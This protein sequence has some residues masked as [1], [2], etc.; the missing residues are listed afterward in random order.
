MIRHWVRRLCFLLALGL[1]VT[2]GIVVVQTNPAPWSKQDIS[3][4]TIALNEAAAIGVPHDFL[5]EKGVRAVH[6]VL[7][8]KVESGAVLNEV[9]SL[10]YRKVFQ[11]TLFESQSFLAAFDQQLTVLPDHAMDMKNNAHGVGIAGHHD[12]HDF[13]ARSNFSGLLNSLDHLKRARTPL[14]RILNANAAQK[15][16]IDLISHLGVA[17]HTVS[18]AYVAPD[19]AWPDAE[20][21][22]VF[23]DMLK[24]FKSAQ[25]ELVNSPAYWSR[26]DAGLARYNELILA[27]QERVLANT[28]AWERR[29]SGRFNSTQTLAP[30]VDL[31]RKLRRL[32]G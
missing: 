32:P 24:S 2:A 1:I 22:T 19:T 16:L 5:M 12:H 8:E 18:V 4:L 26:I 27:V 30:P 9:E 10:E 15:D 7:L 29:V 6:L 23:E 20:L 14:G 31:T 13:S 11:Q 28:S 17:P 3:K 25:F 21:G